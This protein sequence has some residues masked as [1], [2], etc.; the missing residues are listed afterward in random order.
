M[1]KVYLYF[2]FIISPVYSV[3]DIEI[4]P[5]TTVSQLLSF[6]EYGEGDV[7][8][9]LNNNGNICSGGYWL[10]KSDPGFEANLSLILSALHSGSMVQIRAHTDRIWPGSSGTYCHVYLVT[11][12][13]L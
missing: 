4:S 8:A 9:K 5:S 6:S 13:K 12:N 11:I 3:A 10:R 1:K 2:I 7:V